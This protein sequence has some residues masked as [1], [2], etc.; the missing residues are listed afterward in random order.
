M[1]N[2]ESIVNNSR[3][4][5]VFGHYDLNNKKADLRF[6]YIQANYD[7]YSIGSRHPLQPRLNYSIAVKQALKTLQTAFKVLFKAIFNAFNPSTTL[8]ENKIGLYSFIRLSQASIG[9][10][11]SPINSK[12]S[13]YLIEDAAIHLNLYLKVNEILKMSK[14]LPVSEP[15]NSGT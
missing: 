2:L 1:T 7:D 14:N 13:S 3:Y 9:F 15:V 4:V 8:I 10:L 6:S 12:M 5:I 11:V